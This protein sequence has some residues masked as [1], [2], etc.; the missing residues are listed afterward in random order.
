METVKHAPRPSAPGAAVSLP[1]NCLAKVFTT[2]MPSPDVF[3][4][5]KLT[6]ALV[7]DSE[8]T[9]ARLHAVGDVDAARAA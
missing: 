4:R 3:A 8:M 6:L 9:D 7:A 1:P 5:S 2:F